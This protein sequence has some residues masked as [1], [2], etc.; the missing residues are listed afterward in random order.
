L[1]CITEEPKSSNA[2]GDQP[3][4]TKPEDYQHNTNASNGSGIVTYQ[5][6][7]RTTTM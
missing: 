5:N 6:E 4:S 7:I 1:F 2:E 3:S